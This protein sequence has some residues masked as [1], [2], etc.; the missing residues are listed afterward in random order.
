MVTPWPHYKRRVVTWGK[1][2]LHCFACFLLTPFYLNYL[3]L[4]PVSYQHLTCSCLSHIKKANKSPSKQTKKGLNVSLSS[5]WQIPLPASFQLL[6]EQFH[7]LR[8]HI[9]HLHSIL[10]FSVSLTRSTQRLPTS[11]ASEA[12]W[13]LHTKACSQHSSHVVISVSP[14]TQPFHS[15]R[16]HPR[17]SLSRLMSGVR[18]SSSPLASPE[19]YLLNV[20]HVITRNFSALLYIKLPTPPGSPINTSR[21]CAKLNPLLPYSLQNLLCSSLETSVT[22]EAPHCF[23]HLVSLVQVTT[24]MCPRSNALVYKCSPTVH[25]LV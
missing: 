1:C 3:C 20:L 23:P 16:S 10:A 15:L 14:R 25:P 6:A 12:D 9:F 22:L 4:F 7:I 11:Q 21:Q 5:L 19:T 2:L 8:L 24:E 13:L 18:T 17:S